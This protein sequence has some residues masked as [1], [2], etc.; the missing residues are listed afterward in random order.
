MLLWGRHGDSSIYIRTPQRDPA[1]DACNAANVALSPFV[2]LRP[3]KI[4]I[5]AMLTAENLADG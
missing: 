2:P 3:D 4:P 1:T 5:L